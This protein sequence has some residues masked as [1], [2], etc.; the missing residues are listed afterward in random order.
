MTGH[1]LL[2]AISVP[3]R[4]S[5]CLDHIFVR[6]PLPSEA[7]GLVCAFSQKQ[8]ISAHNKAPKQKINLL[9]VDAKLSDIDWTNIFNSDDVDQAAKNFSDILEG[10]IQENTD[11]IRVKRKLRNLKPWITPGLIRCQKNRDRLH[12]QA[13]KNPDDLV[14]QTI[15]KRYFLFALQQRFK[16]SYE[17]QQRDENK[18]NPKRL[19]ETIKDICNISANRSVATELIRTHA[20]PAESVNQYNEYF[21]SIGGNLANDTFLKLNTTEKSLAAEH[22]T[23]NSENNSLFIQSTDQYED[24]NLIE[25]LKNDSAP[26]LDGLTSIIIKTIKKT[27]YRPFN[28]HF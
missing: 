28:T 10:T 22:T 23:S 25:N 13:R 9:A 17:K 12:Q 15:F 11:Y 6:G 18:D 4:G 24:D 5:I 27:N 8:R 21:S 14:C 26:G 3:M 16:I 20:N 1:K 2:P 7:V 19:W